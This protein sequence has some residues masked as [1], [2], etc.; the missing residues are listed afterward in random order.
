MKETQHSEE[1]ALGGLWRDVLNFLGDRDVVP[2][3]L[4]PLADTVLPKWDQ[5]TYFMGHAARKVLDDRAELEADVARAEVGWRL[6]VDHREDLRKHAETVAGREV[7]DDEL[8]NWWVSSNRGEWRRWDAGREG[9]TTFSRLVGLSKNEIDV[10]RS[11]PGFKKFNRTEWLI[12]WL[13]RDLEWVV[14]LE[15]LRRIARKT[16]SPVPSNR[17][18][19]TAD[20]LEFVNAYFVEQQPA[21]VGPLDGG[22]VDPFELTVLNDEQNLGIG[23]DGLHY[24]MYVLLRATV[25]DFADEVLEHTRRPSARGSLWCIDCGRFVGRRALGYGQLYCSDRCKKRAAKRR[26]RSRGRD[27]TAA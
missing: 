20:E 14:D 19:W 1:L 4:L 26:H 9:S 13:H 17:Q 2:S 3:L 10:A 27:Q 24:V 15:D 12:A 23:L 18:E 5:W 11:F 6:W 25:I 16:W 22:P 8:E 21:L 7:A